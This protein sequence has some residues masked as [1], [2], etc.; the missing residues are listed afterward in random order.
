VQHYSCRRPC[1][2]SR[3]SNQSKRARR[4][5]KFARSSMSMYLGTVELMHALSEFAVRTLVAVWSNLCSGRGPFSNPYTI[6]SV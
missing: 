6:A 3:S 4:L 2:V 5:S 1:D